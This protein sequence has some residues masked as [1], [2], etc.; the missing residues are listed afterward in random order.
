MK[1]LQNSNQRRTAKMMR[2]VVFGVLIT[3][4]LGAH[5]AFAAPWAPPP[6]NTVPP[7]NQATSTLNVSNF[8]Q[9]KLGGLIVGASVAPTGVGF[10]VPNGNVGIGTASPGQKLDVNGY[11]RAL[12]FCINS[13]CISSWNINPPGITGVKRIIPGPG[14]GISPLDGKGDVVITNTGTYTSSTAGIEVKLF[15]IPNNPPNHNQCSST[16][17]W[18]SAGV[19]DNGG[20]SWCFSTSTGAFIDYTSDAVLCYKNI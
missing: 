8:A 5:F 7:A 18:T 2:F 16:G 13:D 6:T 9:T 12:A 3:L 15:C 14:I 11:I 1:L 19:L 4:V 10:M 20:H 17:G